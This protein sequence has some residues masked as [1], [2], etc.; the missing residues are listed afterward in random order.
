MVLTKGQIGEI[1]DVILQAFKKESFM[2]SISKSIANIIEKQFNNIISKY[3]AEMNVCK[4]EIAALKNE[5]D[6]LKKQCCTKID[7]LEQYSRRNN[8]RVFGVSESEN[9]NIEDIVSDIV[10]NKMNINLPP[11]YIERCHRVGKKS[12]KPRPIIINFLSYKYKREVF[13][14]KSKLKGTKLIIKE[15]L[16]ALRFAAMKD[17][18][19]RFGAKS[20]WSRDGEVFL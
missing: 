3:E 16:T 10:A 4:T 15:D 5:N 7:T 1:E 9:E 13:F 2:Q 17:L 19:A 20:V 6:T 8:I 14:A 12:G 18:S 11:N